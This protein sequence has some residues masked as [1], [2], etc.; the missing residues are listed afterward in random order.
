MRLTDIKGHQL[1]WNE[2][3]FTSIRW[4]LL[5][6]ADRNPRKN[7][8]LLDFLDKSIV[9]FRGIKLDKPPFLSIK[10][11]KKLKARLNPLI[12][13]TAPNK[14]QTQLRKIIELLERAVNTRRRLYFYY[15]PVHSISRIAG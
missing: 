6:E 12:V 8:P 11:C 2:K 5:F 7:D 10:E 13:D 4:K 15:T 1:S 14:L 9:G 3:E